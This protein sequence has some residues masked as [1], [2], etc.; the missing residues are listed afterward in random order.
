LVS[1]TT[2]SLIVSKYTLWGKFFI[3]KVNSKKTSIELD[4]ISQKKQEICVKRNFIFF[5]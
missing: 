5:F 4:D 2:F 3:I 1:F